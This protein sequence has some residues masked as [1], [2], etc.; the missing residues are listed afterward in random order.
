MI[1]LRTNP[2]TGITLH[3][4]GYWSWFDPNTSAKGEDLTTFRLHHPSL[5]KQGIFT[6]PASF[7]SSFKSDDVSG[8]ICG[9][10]VISCFFLCDCLSSINPFQVPLCYSR[11]HPKSVVS[12]TRL[13]FGGCRF[14]AFPL[15]QLTQVNYASE[16]FKRINSVCYDKLTASAWR[17]HV[18][19]VGICVS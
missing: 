17:I 1:S 5:S 3:H 10:G 9:A 13:T 14:L 19:F 18:E 8:S 7:F 16:L 6:N 2:R 15:L 4:I 12:S 11:Q